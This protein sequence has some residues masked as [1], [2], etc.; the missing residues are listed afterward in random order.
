[1][2]SVNGHL[3]LRRSLALAKAC[4][5]SMPTALAI[6]PDSDLLR[7]NL[8]P[9]LASGGETSLTPQALRVMAAMYLQAELEQAGIIPVVEMLV[10]ARASLPLRS[11]SAAR[12]LE[13][14]AQRSSDY[15]DRGHREL[16][17]ARLFG[18]GGAATS[19]QGSSINREF[20]QVFATLCS[21]LLR[22][23]DD[24]SWG[25]QPGPTREAS[26][27]HAALNVLLNLAP[28]QFG[29]TLIAA[30]LIGEQLQRSIDILSDPGIGAHFLSRGLWDTLRKI[31]GAQTP[32]LGRLTTRGQTGL[33]LLNWLAAAIPALSDART[34][35]P[36]VATNDQAFVWAAQWLEATGLASGSTTGRMA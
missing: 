9:L 16:I 1:M 15:Y 22:Y 4:L 35:R 20:Q 36:L 24:L 33:H 18:T 12:K 23:A 21:A 30:R 17:F 5:W 2:Q 8:P 11:A 25:Q 7:L 14:F 3:R 28:R 34:S 29:N 19:D 6:T 27:R 31:L 26:L 13:E 10:Q 32:D